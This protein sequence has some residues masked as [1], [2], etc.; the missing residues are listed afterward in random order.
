MQHRSGTAVPRLTMKLTLTCKDVERG[1]GG[2][3]F[4]HWYGPRSCTRA[5]AR[6]RFETVINNAKKPHLVRGAWTEAKSNRPWSWQDEIYCS[7]AGKWSA[8]DLIKTSFSNVQATSALG[9]SSS[10]HDADSMLATVH[11]HGT[12]HVDAGDA[13]T[14]EL[15]PR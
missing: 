5:K 3:M 8:L 14:H 12:S 2:N 1:G 4:L 6:H 13:G 15:E 9:I 10:Q 7:T 11:R